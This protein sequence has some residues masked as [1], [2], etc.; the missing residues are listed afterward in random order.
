[1][2]VGTDEAAAGEAVLMALLTDCQ[3]QDQSRL[4]GLWRQWQGLR[5]EAGGAE[6]AARLWRKLEQQVRASAAIT[7]QRR[8]PLAAASRMPA[9]LP[10]T[11]CRDELARAIG[12]GRVSI[13][14]GSTGSGKS[15]Q[16][17][18]LA[19]AL[20]RGVSGRVGVTQPRRLAARAI[21]S[22]LAA[23]LEVEVGGLVGYQTRFEQ[24]LSA[25][26]RVK[27][28]TDG[29][30]LQELGRDRQ[31]LAYDTLII[32]EVHERS[33]NIDFLLGYLRKLLMRRDDLTLILTSATLEAERCAEFFGDAAIV[34]VPGRGYPVDI[35]H[36][37]TPEGQESEPAQD[38]L[39]AIAEL[40][41][42]DY[43][44]ILVFLP[45][46]REIADTGEALAKA[47]LRNT[48]VL[49]LYARLTAR[50]QQ[51]VFAPHQRRHVI[52]ATNVAETSLTVPGVRHVIDTGLVRLA[53]YSPRSR[54]QRL[55][56][57]PNSQAS[58]AQRAGR[59]GRERPGIC[60]RLYG[61]DEFA[62]RPAHT[63]P[64]LQRSNLAG[65]LLRL[66]ELRL[67]PIESFSF[68]DPPDQRAINDGYMLLRE[69]G[70]FDA[71]NRL[72]RR[73]AALARLPL[74][75]RLGAVL[76]AA[77]EEGAVAEALI[78]VAA[79]SVGDVRDWPRDQR[80]AADTAH[81]ASAD[82]RSEFMWLLSAWTALQD[83][84]KGRSRRQQM[85]CCRARF[86]SWRRAR[87]WVAVHA[88]LA[89]ALATLGIKPNEQAAS[90][91]AVHTALLAGFATRIGRL[92][93]DQRYVGTRGGRFRLHPTSS[94]R[95]APPRWVMAA[96]LTET[97]V[98]Y[99]R[100]A[101]RI[102]TPWVVKAVPSLIR[103]SHAEPCWDARQGRALV[104]EEQSLQGLV[105]S[106][107]SVV[108]YARVDAAAA[109]EIF[110][111]KALVEGELGAE[112]PFLAR[113][114][115]LLA[116]VRQWE[117]RVRRHDLLADPAQLAGFYRA[118]L[119]ADIC[120][121]RQLLA[122]L[123]E[124]GG[125]NA[126]LSM[127]E[128]DATQA[129]WASVGRH[130][131][132]ETLTAAGL[133]LRLHYR[134]EPGAEDD[135]VSVDVPAS[136]LHQVEAAHFE[137]LVP[138]LLRDKVYALLK[139]LPKA[140]RRVVSPLNAFAASL[141]AAVEG[142]EGPLTG[143]L[144]Q[145]IQRMTG[146]HIEPTAWHSDD[147][148]AHLMMRFQVV[149]A[150]GA[151]LAAGRDL[152][153]LA[154]ELAQAAQAAFEQARWES[155]ARSGGE[156]IFGALP[157]QVSTV[158]Q[159][160][161]VLGHPALRD[162]GDAVVLIVLP[163]A[164]GARATHRAGVVALL[165]LNLGRELKGLRRH[166]GDFARVALQARALGWTLAFD[167]WLL[168]GA[169]ASCV[170]ED[171]PRDAECFAQ[172]LADARRSVTG[173]FED[174]ARHV[175]EL[176]A[177]SVKIQQI[178]ERVT[179]RARAEVA[180]DLRAQL[181]ELTAPTTVADALRQSPLHIARFLRAME[182]RLERLALDPDKD[183]RKFATLSALLARAALLLPHA[184]Q[185]QHQRVCYL[186]QE[187]RV[188]VF[189]PEVRTAET[190]SAKR[191]ETM[192]DEIA[193]RADGRR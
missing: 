69:L 113:N 64:E 48:D 94:L 72:T 46:E 111:E 141:T 25:A 158:A 12:R 40:D 86:W 173:H 188:A 1:M 192:L 34:H 108:D 117:E 163:D 128:A 87:E 84:F 142:L 133:S 16:L 24:Q 162:E 31:L 115:E 123:R 18:K 161:A 174:A 185:G 127:R 21:A 35:R 91:R 17:P 3:L 149:G 103:R 44:D 152:P 93:E 45:G 47:G 176:F 36:R 170:G 104:R 131:F 172:L 75:P 160:H 193:G 68:L 26:T 5:R 11:A 144:A 74:D 187:L 178:L 165:M 122:W 181:R 39:Q 110:I 186:L 179:P 175:A 182:R 96:E 121:R 126:L 6:R 97:T 120:S 159:G 52:L 137:R 92:G 95:A 156:W 79:L 102:E 129:Q 107:D 169:V 153:L 67:G 143:S 38:I 100:I 51:R 19:L 180:A 125:R 59:C 42:E 138:G 183:F 61:E 29:I 10:I 57:V 116:R 171:A 82:R 43:G 13:V 148:P 136:V 56:T 155:G 99:A 112:P 139:G 184:T 7:A 140:Q 132:P 166:L 105:L 49:P 63:P 50:E 78:I 77:E 15:T 118:R 134:F 62:A 190:V 88:Q 124:E 90:Y 22:R 20:G 189:A 28:M 154:R 65:V 41:A 164:E 70:A 167:E 37:T 60:I 58:A 119:P 80:Q 53:T 71:D 66:A 146:Q 150:D 33:L 14:C 8:L 151:V 9:G 101:A 55:P 145:E 89:T 76:L 2:A 23:E 4:R 130:L 114:R 191:I 168:R 106:A 81:A 54:L 30:L 147:L 98:A 157:V 135:G 73:G 83:E 109:R 177:Q 85:A 27:V 32:D